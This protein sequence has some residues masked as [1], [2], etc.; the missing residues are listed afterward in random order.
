LSELERKGSF[1]VSTSEATALSSF[2][3]GRGFSLVDCFDGETLIESAAD[4]DGVKKD[5]L[6]NLHLR[7]VASLFPL[8]ECP[9]AGAGCFVW[10]N[11]FETGLNAN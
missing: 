6:S 4:L 9:M 10:E 7:E 5:A 8:K 3:T 1:N 11:D 2:G